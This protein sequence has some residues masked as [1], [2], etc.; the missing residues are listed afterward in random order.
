MGATEIRRSIFSALFLCEIPIFV[1]FSSLRVS[2]GFWGISGSLPF[3]EETY[4][5]QDGFVSSRG[6]KDSASPMATIKAR[7][8]ATGSIRYTAIVRKRV[9]N[10][11]VHREAKTFTH[12]TAGLSW[13]RHREVALEDPTHWWHSDAGRADPLVHR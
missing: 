2:A 12:R 11:I 8:Q 10:K 5:R 13:A 3:A 6:D 7:R 9:G 4:R 1:G